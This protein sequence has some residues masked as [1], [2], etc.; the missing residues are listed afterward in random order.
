MMRGCR[1]GRFRDLNLPKSLLLNSKSLPAPVHVTT[2]VPL[3][4]SLRVLRTSAVNYPPLPHES[5][6]EAAVDME[7]L[8]GGARAFGARE[9]A[10]CR[11]LVR[12]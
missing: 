12:R 10:D 8:A 1:S 2:F 3:C 7:N 6:R 5:V 9:E 11:G 4:V